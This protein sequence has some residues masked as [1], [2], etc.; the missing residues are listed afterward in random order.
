MHIRVLTVQP[1]QTIGTLAA[2]MVGVDRKLD[3]SGC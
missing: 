1:G 3:L 2:Q